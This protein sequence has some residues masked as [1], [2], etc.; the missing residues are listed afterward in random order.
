M[1]V[2]MEAMVAKVTESANL[3]RAREPPKTELLRYVSLT[4]E[5]M[6]YSMLTVP[7]RE[8]SGNEKK[9]TSRNWRS[10]CETTKS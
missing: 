9:A 3:A 10:K 5:P 7:P 1:E 4:L 6:P 2:K 8:P